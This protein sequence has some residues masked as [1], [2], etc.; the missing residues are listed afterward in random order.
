MARTR[1]GRH[2]RRELLKDPL[3]DVEGGRIVRGGHHLLATVT[4]HL[5]RELFF[6]RPTEDE[7]TT[8]IPLDRSIDRR[9]EQIGG[10]DLRGPETRPGV[11]TDDRLSRRKSPRLEP[12]LRRSGGLVTDAEISL[13][14]MSVRSENADQLEILGVHRHGDERIAGAVRREGVREKTPAPL[15]RVADA[16]RHLRAPR[17]ERTANRMRKDH[18]DVRPELPQ[19]ADRILLRSRK[20]PIEQAGA[21][22][23]WLERPSPPQNKLGGGEASP[24][25]TQRGNRHHS[26]AEPVREADENPPRVHFFD[27][28]RSRNDSNRFFSAAQR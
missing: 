5:A 2:Q 17:F 7:R 4:R 1:V 8:E 23:E 14:G 11:P 3:E 10:I 12:L 6:P 9:P 21:R 19:L 18:R 20:E 27:F 22:Q 26:I 15:A 16:N 25:R 28:S 13:G 24:Q